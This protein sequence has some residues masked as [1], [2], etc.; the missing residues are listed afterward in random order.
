MCFLFGHGRTIL[1]Q[2]NIVLKMLKYLV[3]HTFLLPNINKSGKN[4]ICESSA[5]VVFLQQTHAVCVC[6]CITMEA[7]WGWC[8]AKFLVFQG[9]VCDMY[10]K[11]NG[12]RTYGGLALS[13][14]VIVH[15][16]TP[17]KQTLGTRQRLPTWLANKAHQGPFDAEELPRILF[18]LKTDTQVNCYRKVCSELYKSELRKF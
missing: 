17:G 9:N 11:W 7:K 15:C 4:T 8:S 1:S 3:L 6:V 10:R 13:V 2:A 12:L 16:V 14:I 5:L 18:S